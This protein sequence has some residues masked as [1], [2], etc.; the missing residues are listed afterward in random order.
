MLIPF[1]PSNTS[2]R[3][4]CYSLFHSFFRL[5]QR[6]C[7]LYK[8]P[9]LPHSRAGSDP[10]TRGSGSPLSWTKQL[11]WASVDLR[12]ALLS[13]PV[14]PSFLTP[15]F[16]QSCR[17]VRADTPF[18]LLFSLPPSFSALFCPSPE[19]R[20]DVTLSLG[21]R[22]R[23]TAPWPTSS[24][25]GGRPFT[26]GLFKMNS[27]TWARLWPLSLSGDLAQCLSNLSGHVN[28]LGILLRHKF[29]FAGSE[30]GPGGLL[31]SW[32]SRNAQAALAQGPE[33]A[34]SSCKAE[35]AISGTVWPAQA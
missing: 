8:I 31:C 29:W 25:L 18:H 30:V 13:A 20:E 22:V 7:D 26:Q 5:R 28:P 11:T 35:P 4:H 14:L 16:L 1:I 10:G 15:G 9:Q 32:A 23:G 6:S 27:V 24:A 2:Q 34:L 12:S 33:G 17:D 19:F 21:N 3:G